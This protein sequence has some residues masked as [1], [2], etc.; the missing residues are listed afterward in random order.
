MGVAAFSCPRTRRRPDDDATHVGYGAAPLVERTRTLHALL[1][2]ET[3]NFPCAVAP[4]PGAETGAGGRLRDVQAT[5]RG[6]HAC[7]GVAGYCV[8]NLH[9][10]DHAI[11]GEEC[12]ASLPYPGHLA[13]PSTIL[14]DASDGASVSFSIELF[15]NKFGEPLVLGYCRSL[16]L[17]DDGTGKRVEWLKPVMFSAGAGWLD[18]R[19]CLKNKAERGMLVAKVGGPAYRIGM[20]G[21][22]ASSRV[23]SD[24]NSALDFDAVQS[25]VMPRCSTA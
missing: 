4:F 21:G 1:T 23:A 14:K 10:P 25:A 9:L 5:G 6:A 13:T 20:G 3:H 2:A 19:H 8:G 12:T 17:P 18:A 15:G 11:A 16:G 22:A 24:G 7:A